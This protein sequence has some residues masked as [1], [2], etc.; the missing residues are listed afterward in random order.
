V[1]TVV[2]MAAAGTT[3]VILGSLGGEW[4]RLDLDGVGSSSW[5]AFGYLVLVGSVVAYSAY[6][7]LLARAPLSLVTTYAYVREPRG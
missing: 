3:M 2:E 6:V 7:W 4:G 5:I 1:T